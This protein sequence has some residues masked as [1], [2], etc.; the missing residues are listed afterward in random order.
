MLKP[1]IPASPDANGRPTYHEHVR[2]FRKR[3]IERTL[4]EHGG[5]RS[6]TARALGLQRTY[7][8]RLIRELD[9][10]APYPTRGS[11]GW[12]PSPPPPHPGSGPS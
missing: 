8:L 4:V 9:V 3:L 10:Q 2:E 11:R 12:A 5:N 7:L 1:V 6:R